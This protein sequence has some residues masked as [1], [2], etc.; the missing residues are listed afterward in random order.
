[1]TFLDIH[2]GLATTLGWVNDDRIFIFG[3]TTTL[4]CVCYI[5]K[6]TDLYWLLKMLMGFL[7]WCRRNSISLCIIQSL[8]QGSS[9][10]NVLQH[11]QPH[12]IKQKDAV[13]EERAN[14]LHD[15]PTPLSTRD[16]AD[17]PSPFQR[18]MER[19]S[20][21]FCDVCPWIVNAFELADCALLSLSWLIRPKGRSKREQNWQ[22]KV[23]LYVQTRLGG[24]RNLCLML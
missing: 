20:G 7:W 19:R 10:I 13:P 2:N 8:W 6:V 17:P 4:K 16:L 14:Q 12:G 1:M 23:A 24:E 15:G 21:Y 5:A 22:R 9:F 18:Q 3:W 11:V